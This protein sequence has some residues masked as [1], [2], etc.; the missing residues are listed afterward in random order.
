L[1]S[2]VMPLEKIN[3]GFAALKGGEVARQLVTFE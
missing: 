2:A 3:D 1:I